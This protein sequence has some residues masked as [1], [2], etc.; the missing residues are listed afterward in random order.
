[1]NIRGKYNFFVDLIGRR[2]V[3]KAARKWIT[4]TILSCW[5]ELLKKSKVPVRRSPNHFYNE[6][7]TVSQLTSSLG[8][9]IQRPSWSLRRISQTQASL[10]EQVAENCRGDLLNPR[11]RT[12]GT[13]Q[14]H[15]LGLRYL[16]ETTHSGQECCSTSCQQDFFL[17]YP[18]PDL[19]VVMIY[20]QNIS[21]Y[22][23]RLWKTPLLSED[24]HRS[25]ITS[26]SSE[27]WQVC[28]FGE[29]FSVIV[30]R[31]MQLWRCGRSVFSHANGF[32]VR[33]QHSN[34]GVQIFVLQKF[35]ISW[36]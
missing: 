20:P 15:R 16:S 19:L 32:F 14:R 33:Q 25:I 7:D 6:A 8:R 11:T 34:V 3:K 22:I 31:R 2:T 29:W 5:L 18:P 17:V 21:W 30:G 28:R 26:G 27:F 13:D 36:Y 23:H 1:M 24:C 4:F 12:N 10:E 9:Q 35:S